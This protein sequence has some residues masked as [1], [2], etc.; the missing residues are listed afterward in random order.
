MHLTIPI[1]PSSNKMWRYGKNGVFKTRE[2]K[3]YQKHIGLLAKV[4]ARKQGWTMTEGEKIVIY[5]TYYWP[6]NRNRDTGN[7][8]KVINDGLEGVLYDNDRWVLERDMD[9]KIDRGNPRI[10]LK[11]VKYATNSD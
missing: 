7:Q 11:I 1:A 6:D 3:D 10:E 8:K 5:Y 9:F 4:E 2:C